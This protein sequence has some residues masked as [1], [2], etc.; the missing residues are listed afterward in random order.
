MRIKFDLGIDNI[1]SSELDLFGQSIR[2]SDQIN[3][4]GLDIKFMI[5]SIQ[6]CNA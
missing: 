6:A 4:F 2:S 1:D 3:I 5:F